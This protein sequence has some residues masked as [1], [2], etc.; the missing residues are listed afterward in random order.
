MEGMRFRSCTI[1]N[2]ELKGFN[3]TLIY[4]GLCFLVLSI[5]EG[6]YW[7]NF[8]EMGKLKCDIQW[9]NHRSVLIRFSELRL[10]ALTWCAGW[11]S[12]NQS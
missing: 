5:I 11:S 1:K 7:V 10:I 9:M 2:G 6:K 8:G 4:A 3:W 12:A